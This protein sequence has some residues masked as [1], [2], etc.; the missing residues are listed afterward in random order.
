MSA[1]E[2]ET[3][4]QRKDAGFDTWEVK[5]LNQGKEQAEFI[6]DRRNGMQNSSNT[7]CE[8]KHLEPL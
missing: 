1:Q 2:V 5:E 8:S 3:V 4:K 6:S 7:I